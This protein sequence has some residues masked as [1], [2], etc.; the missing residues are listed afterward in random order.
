[1]NRNFRFSLAAAAA[2]AIAVVL[3]PDLRDGGEVYGLAEAVEMLHKAKTM[4]MR[5][6]GY[7]RAVSANSDSVVCPS[8]C[9]M[10]VPGNR[11][12]QTSSKA[13]ESNGTWQVL[14]PS[15]T[16]VSDAEYLMRVDH[17]HR[18]ARFEKLFAAQRD[19]MM[20]NDGAGLFSR[21]SIP[22][23]QFKTYVKAGQVTLDGQ[24]Y[25]VYR[26]QHRVSETGHEMRD[27][28]WVSPTTGRI[29]K[30]QFWHR[31]KGD[32][33]WN[34]SF[35]IEGVEIDVKPPAGIF[36]MNAPEG[37]TLEN[38]RQTA[39]PHPAA[40]SWSWDGEVT[41]D[42]HIAFTLRD[43]SLLVCWSAKA[44][45]QAPQKP[46]GWPK[47]EYGGPL[48]DLIA[49][50]NKVE[51]LPTLSRGLEPCAG[52]FV[53]WSGSPDR[54]LAWCIYVPRQ[55]RPGSDKVVNYL[56]SARRGSLPNSPKEWVMVRS[57]I[58]LAVT[59]EQHASYMADAM[60]VL[61]DGK[62]VP[63]PLADY[64]RLLELAATIRS[65]PEYYPSAESQ[66]AQPPV[67]YAVPVPVVLPADAAKQ[68][69]QTVEAFFKA[70]V[71]KQE[72]QAR[73][74]LTY[75]ETRASKVVG[76]LGA[77]PGIKD[78]KVTSVY[79]VD[80]AAL[81]ITSEFD[82]PE[83]QRGGLAVSVIRKGDQ[84]RIRDFDFVPPGRQDD[85]VAK[86]KKAFPEAV[87]FEPQ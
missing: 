1:M 47:G 75:D 84:W 49:V 81:V 86:F 26:R 70:V 45:D 22:P 38:T 66:P 35:E 71:E 85:E 63:E 87:R 34:L 13:T 29:G 52:R 73:S 82:F 33:S 55:E 59:P 11:R 24:R 17:E 68:T 23:D 53:T 32:M 77:L 54:P 4:H 51:S 62:S 65:R 43:G 10:D 25:E 69:R 36:D 8:E 30:T 20:L 60:R 28:V 83:G 19:L 64:D 42:A 3:W 18:T 40:A 76:N 39:G 48:P 61:W 7:A 44:K 80:V 31:D 21:V 56:A 14:D 9:W 41:L 50:L 46:S 37:Y 72:A 78:A 12:R 58:S 74:M 15:E 79:A 5:T 6:L 27:D 67:A 57:L 2:V 16:L